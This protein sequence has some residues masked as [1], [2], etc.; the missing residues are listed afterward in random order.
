M[1]LIGITGGV[2]TG[3]S[4]VADILKQYDCAVVDADAIAKEIVL[5]GKPAYIDIVK[6]FGND[7]IAS[8]GFINRT[9]LANIIFQNDS[10]KKV[11][12]KLTHPRIAKVML[13]QIIKY[14][15]QGKKFVILDIPLLIEAKVWLRFI[16]YTLVVF[17]EPNV[18]LERLQR[19]N[20]FSQEEAEKYISGQIPVRDKLKFATHVIDNNGTVEETKQQV[21]NFHAMLLQQW[22]FNLYQWIV[23]LILIVVLSVLFGKYG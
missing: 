1:F 21:Q 14:F 7:I 10:M 2:A 11:L 9:A 12:N 23:V 16:R 4:T 13:W 5:P 20:D 8:D 18:Q 6:T 17:C 22:S 15:F 19:R 3:K